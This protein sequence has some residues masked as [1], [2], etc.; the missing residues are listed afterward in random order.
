LFDFS[1]WLANDVVK[2]F[3]SGLKIVMFIDTV[4]CLCMVM[5]I[6]YEVNIRT[7]VNHFTILDFWSAA[8][9]PGDVCTNIL[10]TFLEDMCQLNGWLTF[11]KSA[12][13]IV[14]IFWSFVFTDYLL[15]CHYFLLALIV[16]IGD[17]G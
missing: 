13:F 16:A 3:F 7:I 5:T 1:V 10:K 12:V 4:D 17:I 14:E 6:P 9:R 8:C 11:V 2:P 15:P